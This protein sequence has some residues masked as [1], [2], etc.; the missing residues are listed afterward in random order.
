[1]CEADDEG[2]LRGWSQINDYQ[3]NF[4]SFSFVCFPTIRDMIFPSACKVNDWGCSESGIRLTM[5]KKVELVV[6]A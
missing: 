5:I 1:M 6:D 2:R 4:V 3:V